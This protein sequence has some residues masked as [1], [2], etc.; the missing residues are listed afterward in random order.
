LNFFI[1]GMGYSMVL[2]AAF[3]WPIQVWIGL[4][5]G[6]ALSLCW[7]NKKRREREKKV[8]PNPPVG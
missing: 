3:Q 6:W 4:S 7:I 1:L 2:S 5:G 8:L